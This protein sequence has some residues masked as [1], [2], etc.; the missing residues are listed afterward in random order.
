MDDHLAFCI[1]AGDFLRARRRRYPLAIINYLGKVPPDDVLYDGRIGPLVQ[2]TI[3]SAHLHYAY[4][5]FGYHDNYFTILWD[6][7]KEYVDD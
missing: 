7:S 2:H 6:F 3:L 1:V 5:Q 4:S